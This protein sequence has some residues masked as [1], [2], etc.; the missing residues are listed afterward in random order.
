[1]LPN[2]QSEQEGEGGERDPKDHGVVRTARPRLV[3]LAE[4]DLGTDVEVGPEG[5][6]EGDRGLGGASHGHEEEQ[7]RD[8]AGD[9]ARTVCP[10][11]QG[12]HRP[13]AGDPDPEAADDPG[14]GR[15][16]GSRDPHRPSDDAWRHHQRAEEQESRGAAVDEQPEAFIEG[17]LEHAPTAQRE[18]LAPVAGDHRG[19]RE[20]HQAHATSIPTLPWHTQPRGGSIRPAGSC[21]SGLHVA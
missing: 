10:H 14:E 5:H 11:D 17:E 7:G 8:T 19:P 12:R 4:V 2:E 1:M 18:E 9:E 15:R 20:R 16:P 21:L 13:E 3:E 6:D